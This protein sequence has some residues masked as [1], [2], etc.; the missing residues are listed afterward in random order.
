M[1]FS[2]LGFGVGAPT[3]QKRKRK[4]FFSFHYADIMR[5]NN[6][7]NSGEFRMSGPSAQGA[8]GASQRD[9]EGYYDYSLWERRK[10]DGPDALKRMIREGV[11]NT[12]AVCLLVGAQTYLRPWVRYEIAR[13]V[14]DERGLLA[15]HINNINHHVER[16]P[17][18]LGPNPLG[19]MGVFK[20]QPNALARPAYYLAE[21]GVEGRW[22]RY[23][24][25]TL[26]VPKPRYLPE[27]V[28]D[29]VTAL[30]SGTRVHDFALQQGHR[31]MGGWIDQ[32]AQAVGR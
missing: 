19:Y 11:E 26:A 22:V 32:A 12:S 29:H 15:V 7:R 2:N 5:V 1:T 16:R 18:A 25:Y 17:H 31:L 14:I 28:E 4:V 6:V 27:P 10:L 30:S 20:H 8:L 9:V 24:N 23:A 21:I 13:S 3:G